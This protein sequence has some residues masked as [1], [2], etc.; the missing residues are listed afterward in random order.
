MRN[1][2]NLLF[3]IILL[4]SFGSVFAD[5]YDPKQ[6]VF[7]QVINTL[8][9]LL[10]VILFKESEEHLKKSDENS[11]DVKAT[12]SKTTLDKIRIP[13]EIR[14]AFDDF[15]FLLSLFVLPS[16]VFHK[17][18]EKF[19]TPLWISIFSG[20]T[21]GFVFI[22]IIIIYIAWNKKDDS[23]FWWIAFRILPFIYIKSDVFI[24]STSLQ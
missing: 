1:L 14:R 2:K 15:L 6:D 16:I 10:I 17:N 3:G 21:A 23:I 9:P 7:D 12:R 18:H 8:V 5:E 19:E 22:S 11:D 13:V 4:S 24:V 20:V